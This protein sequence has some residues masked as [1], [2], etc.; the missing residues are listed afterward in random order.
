[1]TRTS[2]VDDRLRVHLAQPMPQ[3]IDE[4]VARMKGIE[5]IIG[6]Q[7]GLFPFAQLYRITTEHIGNKPASFWQDPDRLRRL[8]VY[9]AEAFFEALRRWLG[10]NPDSTPSA[11][12]VMFRVRHQPGI[13]PLRRAVAGMNAHINRDLSYCITQVWAESGDPGDGSGMHVD[14]DRVNQV[15]GETEPQAKAQLFERWMRQLDSAAAD[16]DDVMELWSIARARDMAWVNARSQ[17]A[18]RDKVPLRNAALS[19]T[20]KMAS[21]LGRLVLGTLRAT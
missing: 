18:L 17:W 13:S 16:I 1:M 3:T 19:G 12:K 4:A 7:D 6:P 21:Y 14:F 2:D 5:A 15:L 20:D 8:D 9:F 10:P 11:W